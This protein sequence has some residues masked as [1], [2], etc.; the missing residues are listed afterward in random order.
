MTGDH[1]RPF[2]VLAWR[3]LSG[4]VSPLAPLLLRERA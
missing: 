3:A 4:M 2:G 1:P